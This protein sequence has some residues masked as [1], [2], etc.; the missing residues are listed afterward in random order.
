[1]CGDW[2]PLVCEPAKADD[3]HDT[4]HGQP[5]NIT[6]AQKNQLFVENEQ[7]DEPFAGRI[8][9]PVILEA[10]NGPARSRSDET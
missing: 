8:K 9:K 6:K 7:T 2:S 5:K 4:G 3:L 10:V 1:M